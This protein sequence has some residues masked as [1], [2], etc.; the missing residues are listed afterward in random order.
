M[1][2]AFSGIIEVR[3]A[4]LPGSTHK[5]SSALFSLLHEFTIL[6]QNN[7]TMP[8][9]SSSNQST[10]SVLDWNDNDTYVSTDHDGK[11]AGIPAMEP[12]TRT[13]SPRSVHFSEDDNNVFFIPHLDDFTDED[14][15]AIWYEAQDYADMK[16]DYKETIFLMECGTD[17]DEQEYTVR[18]LEYRT[19]E[20][21]WARYENKR[22]AYNAVLDE[23]DIQWKNDCDDHEELRKVYL[24]HS[25]KCSVAAHKL[26]LEDAHD[27]HAIFAESPVLPSVDKRRSNGE[28]R[29][30]S[31]KSM[32]SFGGKR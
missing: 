9:R 15:A 25:T 27:A 1:S 16:S 28:K 21:A 5:K 8:P 4:S 18:G 31:F 10:I 32:M 11:A 22:D 30:P 24:E 12:L 20:G 3:P 19:Q 29:S 2:R 6:C 23:Q 26:A 7:E 14:V 13:Q 17:L